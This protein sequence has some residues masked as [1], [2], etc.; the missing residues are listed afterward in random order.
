VFVL[1][2]VVGAVQ[3]A[4]LSRCPNGNCPRP[5]VSSEASG[6]ARVTVT[7]G[8]NARDVDPVTHVVVKADTGKLT[9]VRM[10]NDAGKPVA[11]VMTPD[12]TVWKPTV[13]LGYGRTY[14][15]ALTSRGPNGVASTEVSR[16]STLQPSNQTK[17]T[18]TTTSEA[19]LHEGGT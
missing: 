15:L 12:N 8:P 11:G 7:P 10:V 17:V 5:G 19:A 4:S 2:G 3:I 16:F 6:P 18:F 1:V 14:T 9:D 13:P